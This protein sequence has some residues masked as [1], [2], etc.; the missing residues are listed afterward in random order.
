MIENVTIKSTDPSMSVFDKIL[1]NGGF[2]NGQLYCIEGKRKDRVF[3]KSVMIGP[4]KII[5]IV[6]QYNDWVSNITGNKDV[7]VRMTKDFYDLVIRD[8]KI[9]IDEI[10]YEEVMK[11]I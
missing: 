4:N 9:S 11:R 1:M 7:I 10:M 6:C 8:G 3:I 5:D 2:V